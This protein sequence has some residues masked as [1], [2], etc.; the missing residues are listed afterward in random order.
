MRTRTVVPIA[1]AL[2]V[3]AA[4]LRLGIWQLDRLGER[5]ARNAVVSARLQ[6]APLPLDR[7]L[8][9][10]AGSI[11]L[12]SERRVR[13][14]APGVDARFDY[15]NE[16]VLTSRT[17]NGAPGVHVFTPLQLAGRDTAILVNRGWV[18]SPDGS[19]LDLDGW[20]EA[21]RPRGVAYSAAWPDI[22]DRAGDVS[23]LSN[24][25]GVRR[26]DRR[27]IAARM[28]YPIAD[29]Y[30]VLAADSTADG[31][32][33][34]AVSSPAAATPARLPPPTV[35]EGPHWSYAVQWFSFAFIAV[36]GVAAL[37]WTQRRDRR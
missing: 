1:V 2:V 12:E 8:P 17:H 22:G 14:D 36:A 3:A 10:G 13:L 23:S 19:A 16:I 9:A 4:C 20:R 35:S 30:L 26:L 34:A 33:A 5:R 21:E 11:A 28:P 6:A 7:A 32:P 24:P 18:Y 25:R 31:A 15:R 29:F 27:T 37:L